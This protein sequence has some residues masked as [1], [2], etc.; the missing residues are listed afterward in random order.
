MSLTILFKEKMPNIKLQRTVQNVFKICYK[1][2]ADSSA[3]W[4][5][6]R[7]LHRI[8]PVGKYLKKINIKTSY[9]CGFCMENVESIIH[10]FFSCDKV[11][12]L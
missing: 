1:T 5:Q 7:I 10:V 12:T 11:Q 8:V 6:F 4:L 3:Q 9:C 2:T